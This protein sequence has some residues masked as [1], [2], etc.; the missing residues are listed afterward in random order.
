MAKKFFAPI[1]EV[2]RAED[3]SREQGT[4]KSHTKLEF[5]D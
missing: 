4:G 5:P 2:S 3:N 1:I